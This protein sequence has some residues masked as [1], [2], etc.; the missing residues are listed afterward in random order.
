MQDIYVWLP[1][2]TQHCPLENVFGPRE[3]MAAKALETHRASLAGR[4]Q[5]FTVFLE[6]PAMSALLRMLSLAPTF[7]QET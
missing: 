2:A 4:K 6:S 1:G 3:K 7:I 5:S